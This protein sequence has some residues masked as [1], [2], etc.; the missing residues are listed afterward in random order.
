MKRSISFILMMTFV[1][2]PAFISGSMAPNPGNILLPTIRV[3]NQ[4]D[5]DEEEIETVEAEVKP[6]KVYQTLDGVFE[7]ATTHEVETDFESWSDL[8]V[9]SIVEQGMNVSDGDVLVE[10]EVEDLDEAIRDARF[11]LIAAELDMQETVLKRQQQEKIWEMDKVA[12]ERDWAQAQE[13]NDYYWQVEV[14]QRDKDLEFDMET[15]GYSLEYAKDE[16]DQLLQMYTEDELTEESEEIVLKRARRDVARSEWFFEL[17]KEDLRRRQ[18][19][20][21]PRQDVVKKEDFERAQMAHDRAMVELEGSMQ[22]MDIEFQRAEIALKE[23]QEKLADLEADREGMSLT[24]PA[25]G[26]LFYGSCDRGEWSDNDPVEEGD[27]MSSDSVV[28]TIVDASSMQ[29]RASVDEDS[30]SMINDNMTGLALIPAFGR[31][32]VGV[33]V[34][35]V[36]AIPMSDGNYDCVI[37]ITGDIPEGVIP[38][39][40]CKLSF[41]AYAADVVVVP[42]DSVFSDDGGITHYVYKMVGGNPAWERVEIGHSSDGMV[43]IVDG[44]SAGDEITVEKQ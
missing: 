7:A 20:I 1:M 21:N 5:E 44:L 13:D 10:F 25:A 24:A 2:T 18:E 17:R 37:E 39:M 4:D 28:M 27:S 8:E 3:T 31:E 40:S 15:A 42:E 26:M 32:K 6:I 9:S 23:A 30:V 19:V 34:S 29:I 43:E 16:L 36:S 35:S 41:V 38:G 22:R 14:P 12:A 11:E 33:S